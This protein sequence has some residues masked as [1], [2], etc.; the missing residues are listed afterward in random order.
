MHLPL[1]FAE[2]KRCIFRIKLNQ[3]TYAKKARHI[4]C[5]S[6]NRMSVPP[7]E[8][9]TSVLGASAPLE[10]AGAL[11]NIWKILGELVLFRLTPRQ[12]PLLATTSYTTSI[13][14]LRNL[15]KISHMH[16]AQLSQRGNLQEQRLIL[17]RGTKRWGVG[18][19]MIIPPR[20]RADGRC[21]L[22]RGRGTV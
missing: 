15:C 20:C 17:C 18:F 5:M 12:N 4:Y 1:P 8:R 22:G 2:Q 21:Q 6:R 10:G 3:H 19:H 16:L 13:T 14:H 11:V 7:P 9:A